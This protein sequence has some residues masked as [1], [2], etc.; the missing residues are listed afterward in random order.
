MVTLLLFVPMQ[1]FLHKQNKQK[2]AYHSF[3][4]TNEV[5]HT[6]Q[7]PFNIIINTHMMTQIYID[8]VAE[9]GNII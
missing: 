2:I 7:I 5:L 1:F 3:T 8:R 9:V 6:T 4:T